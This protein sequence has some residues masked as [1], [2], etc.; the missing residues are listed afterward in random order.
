M[1]EYPWLFESEGRTHMLYNGN[2]YGATG[3]G[4]AVWDG[5]AGFRGRGSAVDE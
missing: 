1:V 3:V 4:L 5:E 2:G